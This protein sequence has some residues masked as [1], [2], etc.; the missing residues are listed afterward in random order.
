MMGKIGK[1][2]GYENVNAIEL[3]APRKV[4][5]DVAYERQSQEKGKMHIIT[6]G[7]NR[8]ALI[9]KKSPKEVVKS[10]QAHQPYDHTR[11]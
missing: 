6:P 3:S 1:L 11:E 2:E 10:I 5:L 7:F 9:T 8:E 4:L